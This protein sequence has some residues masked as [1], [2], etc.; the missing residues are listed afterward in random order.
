MAPHRGSLQLGQVR[1]NAGYCT[2]HFLHLTISVCFG[3]SCGACGGGA[4]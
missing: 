3:F 2:P 4:G 1:M